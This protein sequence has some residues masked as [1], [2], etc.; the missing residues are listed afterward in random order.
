MY[1]QQR[2]HLSEP[3]DVQL[4]ST[5]P[6][7]SVLNT[8]INLSEVPA[9]LPFPSQV[10]YR[11]IFSVKD[12]LCL[13]RAW[14]SRKRPPRHSKRIQMWATCFQSRAEVCLLHPKPPNPEVEPCLTL[15]S[16]EFHQKMFFFFFPS[17]NSHQKTNGL[18]R[19]YPALSAVAEDIRQAL[20]LID[21]SLSNKWFSGEGKKKQK[22]GEERQSDCHNSIIKVAH[23]AC[24]IP[25]SANAANS[26]VT[27]HRWRPHQDSHS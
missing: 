10:S 22:H 25:A 4:C 24:L 9:A 12:L 7:L 17:L 8:M 11:D 2:D 23:T 21:K 15:Q 1:R 6:P 26:C 20:I 19:S 18:T 3:E 14:L 27:L 13:P 16:A 5:S